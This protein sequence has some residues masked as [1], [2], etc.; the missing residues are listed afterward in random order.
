M[1]IAQSS[2]TMR[3]SWPSGPGGGLRTMSCHH[4]SLMFFFNSTPSGP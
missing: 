2:P 4:A 1:M 3:I